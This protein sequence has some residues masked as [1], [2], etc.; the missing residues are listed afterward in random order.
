MELLEAGYVIPFKAIPGRYQEKN[1]LSARVNMAVVRDIVLDMVSLKVVTVVENPPHCISPLGLVSKLQPDGTLKH[2]LVFDASRHVNLFLDPEKVRLTHL[3]KALELTKRNDFQVV[4]DLEKAYYHVRVHPEQRQFLGASFE[5]PDGKTIFFVYNCLP[6]GLSTAVHAI[7]KVMKPVLGHLNCKGIRASIF[8]DDGRLLGET[9]EAAEQARLDTY[10][11]LMAAGWAIAQNKSDGPRQASREKDYLGFHI[12][13][14]DML[15]SCLDSKLR[16][17]ETLLEKALSAMAIPV[18]G[19]ASLLGKLVALEP[20][21]AMLSRLATRSGYEALAIHTDTVGWK[22]TILL[23]PECKAELAFFK[24][25]LWTGNG[26]PILSG[27]STVRL[28]TLLPNPVAMAPDLEI[29]QAEGPIIVSDASNVKAYVYGLDDLQDFQMEMTFTKDQ[30]SLSST[31]RELLALLFTLKQWKNQGFPTQT[32]VYWV[33]DSKTATICVEKGSKSAPTQT[34]VFDIAKCCKD[35]QVH[36]IPVHLRREDPRLQEADKGSKTAD[37]DNWSIDYYSFRDLHEIFQFEFD[38]FASHDNAKVP[39]FCSLY[40]QEAAQ[41]TEAWSLD[42]T[43]C[44][45]L[46]LC[47][48]VSL[49]IKVHDRILRSPCKGVL[50]MPMWVTA[51][52][53]TFYF[54]KNNSPRKPF[55]LVKEWH[56][57]I[58]QNEGA[59]HTPLFGKTPFAFV[60]LQFNTCE[61]A[62]M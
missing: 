44:G 9:A 12:N 29:R 33:T 37:S 42:W 48:P 25:H 47:P 56:P 2:R 50:C 15:V 41:A 21:H 22:G 39:K 53:Y 32:A 49:L 1:N 7:T 40:F 11:V 28:E 31:G 34:I 30:Q 19:L 8:I 24:E 59:K 38:M 57:Y 27:L 6:F 17:T 36:V 54:D 55:S 52:Y 43:H 18:K 23:T 60:A 45:M 26:A 46:W 14:S 3:A 61:F 13:T 62:N 20:S 16:S 5:D 51:T 10:E 4:F 35:I 58:V